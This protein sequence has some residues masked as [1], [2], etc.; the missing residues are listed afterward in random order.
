MHGLLTTI[1]IAITIHKQTHKNTTCCYASIVLP[2]ALFLVDNGL[3]LVG[4][5][6]Y[7]SELSA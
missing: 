3:T 5:T 7:F 6:T 1:A 4:L 2:L